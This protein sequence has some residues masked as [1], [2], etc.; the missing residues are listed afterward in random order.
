MAIEP[1]VA[2]S[3][4]GQGADWRVV[5]VVIDVAGEDQRVTDAEVT[6]AELSRRK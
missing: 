4:L 3:R 2:I 6:L 5:I 1:T